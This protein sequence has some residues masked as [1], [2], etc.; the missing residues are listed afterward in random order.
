MEKKDIRRFSILVAIIAAAAATR[1]IPHI[2]NV[3]PMIAIALFGGVHFGQ[4]RWAITL[5]LAAMVISD[6]GLELLS[7]NGFH[8]DMP[9]VYLCMLAI[10]GLGF[11]LKQNSRIAPIA[12]ATLLA[13]TLFFIV[14]N[15]SVWAFGSLYPKT[16]SGLATCYIAAIPYFGNALMGDVFYTA[17]LFGG[18][19]LA[20]RQ[21]PALASRTA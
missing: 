11:V 1:W 19:A 8:S 2:P 21:F 4:K 9:A 20:S 15:F 14:T 17:L 10:T 12:G 7:G 18:Y 5:P 6:L 13:S 3:T 16:F